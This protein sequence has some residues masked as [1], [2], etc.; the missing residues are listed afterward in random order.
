M[1]LPSSVERQQLDEIA[2]DLRETFV[3]RGHRVEVALDVD[4]SFGSGT[5]RSS[6]RRDLVM[7]TVSRSASRLG[8]SFRRV[9]GNGREL[10]GDRHRYRVRKATLDSEGKPIVTV[11]SESAPRSGRGAHALSH[12]VVGVRLGS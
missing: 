5:S 11:S 2:F 4:S 6:L 9:N 3:E 1:S 12:G 8:L 10:F 7:E